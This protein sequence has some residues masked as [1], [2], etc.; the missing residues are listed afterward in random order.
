MLLC[1]IPRT[2]TSVQHKS[3]QNTSNRAN[4]QEA[5]CCLCLQDKADC[6]SSDNNQQCRQN[7]FFQSSFCA[8]VNALSIIGLCLSLHQALNAPEL[9]SDFN[10]NFVR[11]I[12]NS[13]DS[14]AAEEEDEHSANQ[15][16]DKD[17]NLAQVDNPA[18]F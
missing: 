12:A 13:L 1:I 3:H 10:Y 8:N 14:H 17:F 16:A 4:H 11:S 9:S 2:A 5:G 15:C 6:N 7:H 18:S